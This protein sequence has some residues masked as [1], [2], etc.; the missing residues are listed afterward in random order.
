MVTVPAFVVILPVC[1]PRLGI[2]P[3]NLDP[4]LYAVF[5]V[6]I[7]DAT[8]VASLVSA[9]FVLVPVAVAPEGK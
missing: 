5:P 3:V 7:S 8:A 6:K 9:S 2:V 1:C 4:F